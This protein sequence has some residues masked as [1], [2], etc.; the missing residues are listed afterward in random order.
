M[1]KISVYLPDH[2]YR[3]ARERGL[4]ISRIAQDA[5]ERELR[6]VAN[7]DWIAHVSARPP[8]TTPKIDT[9]QL[10]DVTRDE[11]GT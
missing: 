7:A 2:L 1:L 8:R 9:S 11:F 5:I 3:Q 4:S 10:L 6:G